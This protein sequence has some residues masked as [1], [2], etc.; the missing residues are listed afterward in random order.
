MPTAKRFSPNF[1]ASYKGI[2]FYMLWQGTFGNSVLDVTRRIDISESNLPAYMLNRWTG[3]GTSNTIPR[4][5]RGDAVNWQMSDLYVQDGSYMRLKNIQLG[6]T[7][8][9]KWT[10]KIFISSLR[11][12]VGA[13]NNLLRWYFPGCRLR[14]VPAVPHLPL[15]C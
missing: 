10:K 2:D 3:E 14:C 5:V 15:R 12:F 6:Y 7:L 13:E 8:P 4:F 1:S 11:F 9:Q